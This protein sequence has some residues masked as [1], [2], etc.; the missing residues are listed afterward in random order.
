VEPEPLARALLDPASMAPIPLRPLRERQQFY[1]VLTEV[2]SR[3]WRKGGG[4]A[5]RDL[6]ATNDVSWS[7]ADPMPFLTMTA[8]SWPIIRMAMARGVPFGEVATLDVG[9]YD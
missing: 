8:T 3:F 4:R 9:W 7:A 5:A 6:F 2:Q 1:A